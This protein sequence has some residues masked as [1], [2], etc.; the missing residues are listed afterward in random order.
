M[1]KLFWGLSTVSTIA[2]VSVAVHFATLPPAPPVVPPVPNKIALPVV[3]AL[4]PYDMPTGHVVVSAEPYRST[5]R[6]VG[7][8]DLVD[9]KLMTGVYTGTPY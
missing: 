3:P 2:V 7:I 1:K 4:S 5:N 6:S 9:R 8:A